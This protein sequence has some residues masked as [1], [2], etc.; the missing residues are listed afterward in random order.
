MSKRLSLDAF[1]NQ[2][3]N[4]RTISPTAFIIKP[5]IFDRIFFPKQY[6]KYIAD[7]IRSAIIS[8]QNLA[9]L[10]VI[11]HIELLCYKK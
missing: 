4:A 5:S 3:L 7:E 2:I 8:A 9:K 6:E 10:A 11:D 1:E